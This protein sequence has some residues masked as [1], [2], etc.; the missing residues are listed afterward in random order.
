MARSIS[1]PKGELMGRFPG[2][3]IPDSSLFGPTGSNVYEVDGI[4]VHSGGGIT[5]MG[6]SIS[7]EEARAKLVPLIGL[8]RYLLSQEGSWFS[9]RPATFVV[10]DSDRFEE[11]IYCRRGDL[12]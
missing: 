3:S 2:R 8:D 1:E 7:F 12:Q 4:D 6:N 9:G 11:P 5:A 10:L